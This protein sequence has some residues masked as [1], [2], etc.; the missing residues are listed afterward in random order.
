MT[1]NLSQS[2]RSREHQNLSGRLRPSGRFSVA[3]IFPKKSKVLNDDQTLTSEK[4]QVLQLRWERFNPDATDEEREAHLS[5]LL[6]RST[7]VVPN[8]GLSNALNS[9][10]RAR[11][12]RNGLRAGTRD[13]ICWA[14]NQLE[15]AHGRQ[16]MSFLTL[17]L[18]E[19][20][21]M[22]LIRVQDAWPGI[23]D[24]VVREIRRKLKKYGVPTHV[25]GCTEIQPE[26]RSRTGFNYPHLH[27][28]FRGRKHS[29]ANW[30][31][32]PKSFRYIWSTAVRRVL[33]NV[34]L[35]WESSENVQAVRDSAGGYLA[36][37]ISKGASRGTG[38]GRDTWH[39]SHWEIISRN[40]RSLYDRLSYSGYDVA[41]QCL[42][43]V[44]DWKPEMGWVR[45]IEIETPAY[46]RRR[47][48]YFGWV[49]GE[50]RYIS[51][52]ELF[53]LI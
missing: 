24:E 37:Y 48:G 11:R 42:A 47:I 25:V 45:S 27:M 40:L 17:T 19:L 53:A 35:N 10:T 28:V 6:D 13:K 12:G 50:T 30:A 4:I 33:P 22:D 38:D 5:K 43:W 51:R 16:N 2:L 44:R 52:M 23:V 46:G 3:Q 1:F 15:F 29:R 39:P 32:S 20:E 21:E 31:L 9:R 8:V 26:R 18:P 36:K 14:A 49:N 34:Q 41:L 7:K